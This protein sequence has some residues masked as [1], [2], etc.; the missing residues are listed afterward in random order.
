MVT[1]A[2]SATAIVEQLDAAEIQKR[3]ADN[4]AERRALLV[5][6]RAAKAK[7]RRQQ[8]PKEAPHAP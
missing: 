7:E 6:L 5:L 4:A 2:N 1:Q 3:I 8:R